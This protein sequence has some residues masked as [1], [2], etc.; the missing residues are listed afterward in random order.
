MWLLQKSSK[1]KD[2][3]KVKKADELEEKP[4]LFEV[5]T[6]QTT[7]VIEEREEYSMLSSLQQN[8]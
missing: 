2:D 1:I 5:N 4:L 3:E 6:I 8:T 7:L